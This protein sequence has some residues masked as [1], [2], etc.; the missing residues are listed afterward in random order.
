VNV[1]EGGP[2]RD[3]DAHTAFVIR[4]VTVINTNAHAYTY[5]HAATSDEWVFFPHLAQCG[6][7]A[8][9]ARN[10]R[11]AWEAA[12]HHA[13]PMRSGVSGSPSP[14]RGATT[15]D[16]PTRRA[17]CQSGGEGQHVQ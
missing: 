12:S 9:K 6:Q 11:I 4:I 5:A 7:F 15:A 2:D 10:Q 16:D 3:R 8:Y 13:P 1:N 17:A 14:P